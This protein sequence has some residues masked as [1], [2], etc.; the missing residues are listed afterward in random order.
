MELRGGFDPL[1]AL[2]VARVPEITGP[3]ASVL[4][5]APLGG[6]RRGL[7]SNR[8]LAPGLVVYVP[9]LPGARHPCPFSH[10]SVAISSKFSKFQQDLDK[11]KNIQKYTFACGKGHLLCSVWTTDTHR[12]AHP[13]G[14][15]SQLV[16][17]LPIPG[18]F[19]PTTSV[20]GNRR[21]SSLFITE[22]PTPPTQPWLT[23]GLDPPSSVLS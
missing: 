18:A 12:E 23:G 4:W 16:L 14:R 7:S 21:E 2:P 17:V 20:S 1:N 19:T 10:P 5:E 6:Y 22:P 13:A 8:P 11:A 15:Q 9:W 3:C